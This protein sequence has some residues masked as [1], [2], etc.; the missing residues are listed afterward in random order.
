MLNN[1]RTKIG[2]F[3]IWFYK[4]KN[5]NNKN[6]NINKNNINNKNNVC[7]ISLI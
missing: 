6:T 4:L 5:E 2:N 7:I 1:I 3:L